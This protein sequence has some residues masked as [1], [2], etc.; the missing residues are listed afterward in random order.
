MSRTFKVVISLEVESEKTAYDLHNHIAGLVEHGSVRDCF[1]SADLDASFFS[2]DSVATK[3]SAVPLTPGQ[4]V[5]QCAT[6]TSPD[7]PI[8][9]GVETFNTPDDANAGIGNYLVDN[10]IDG[11]IAVVTDAAGQTFAVVVTVSIEPMVKP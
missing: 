1:A 6:P 7:Y 10:L 3:Q 9:W 4:V 8:T 11:D 5:A 2:V